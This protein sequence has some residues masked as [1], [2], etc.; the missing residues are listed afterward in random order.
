MDAFLVL[1]DVD[2]TLFLTPDAVY[3]D[4]LVAAVSDVYGHELTQESF[5]GVDHPGETATR[6][7]RKLLLANGLER[8]VI[9]RGLEQWC[10]VFSRVYVELLAAASTDF[11]E[12]A[13]GAS[14]VLDGLT[15][16]NRLA[17]LTG[18]PEP[19]ARARLERLGLDQLFP[20][21]QGAFGCEADER[22]ELIAL[23]RER[24]GDWPTERT[25]LV[26]DTPRDVEGA[27]AAGVRA[28]GVTSGRFDAAELAQADAVVGALKELPVALRQL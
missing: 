19:V 15:T 16:R 4:A 11:W 14:E 2:G 3:N 26:G 9:D 13:P 20:T 8:A 7:L 10:A 23:A 24:A 1:F 6:G 18:N 17:L 28:V 5:A 27:R 22:H 12:V 21:G 25:V